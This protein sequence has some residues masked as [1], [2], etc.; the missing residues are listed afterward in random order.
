[1]MI[2][3]RLWTL[4]TKRQTSDCVVVLDTDD[5]VLRMTCT[6]PNPQLA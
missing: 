4:S 5:I 6:G 3:A 1:M 2:S